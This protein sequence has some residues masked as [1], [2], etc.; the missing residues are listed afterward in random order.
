MTYQTSA[1]PA[2]S[3]RKKGSC[4]L[5]GCLTVIILFFVSV[6]CL[7]TIIFLPFYTDFDLLGL[8]LRN[9]IEQYIP[10][11]EFLEDP[12]GF[13]GM[14][15][16]FD[17]SFNDL[18]E[19]LPGEI[20]SSGPT[21]G[22]HAIPLSTYVAS[23]FQAIFDYPTGWDIEIEEYGVTFYDTNSYTYLYV[24]ED[25]V[26]TGQNARQIAQDVADSLREESQEGTFKVFESTPFSVQEVDD[27]YLISYEFTDTEGYYQWALDLETVSGES[28]IF[29]YLSGED[30]EDYLLYRELIELIAA[31]F[32]R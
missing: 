24:G 27:A 10:W 20:T 2:E 12:T 25:L 13:P 4:F 21:T 9:R 32:T 1:A 26:D 8:D 7:V 11:Q 17:D 28:N 5:W 14:P 29:F 30:P 23:D 6:C 18:L 19:E 3:T 31:S 22:A 15:E 16:F